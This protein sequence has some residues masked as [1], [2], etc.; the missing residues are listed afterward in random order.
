[1]MSFSKALVK[2]NKFLFVSA[3]YH[4]PSKLKIRGI[5]YSGSIC[6]NNE[7]KIVSQLTPVI[8][9]CFPKT[10]FILNVFFVFFLSSEF[11]YFVFLPS[12]AFNSGDFFLLLNDCFYLCFLFISLMV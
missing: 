3:D 2:T 10:Y 5:Y 4:M 12:P 8:M 1:M 6:D 9:Y 7:L 11:E